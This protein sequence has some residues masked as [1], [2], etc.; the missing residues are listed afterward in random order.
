MREAEAGVEAGTEG[1][2]IETRREGGRRTEV[3]TDGIVIVIGMMSVV[4]QDRHNLMP[5]VSRKSMRE[6]SKSW[7][8]SDVRYRDSGSSSRR[9]WK[10]RG[11][12]G[13]S[14]KKNSRCWKSQGW[15]PWRRS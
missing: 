8:A 6:K 13:C 4:G 3:E 15:R 5:A 1:I 9:K 2:E 10:K 14:S 12:R 11:T 7:S